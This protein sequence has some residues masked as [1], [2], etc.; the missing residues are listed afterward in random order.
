VADLTG[1]S[2]TAGSILLTVL[3]WTWSFDYVSPPCGRSGHAR[4][5]PVLFS[6]WHGFQLPL[7]YTHRREGINVLVSTHRDGEYVARVLGG[8]GFGTI[9]GSTTRGGAEALRKI[10]LSLRRGIDCA[11]TP[12]GPRGP[13]E[14][15]KPGAAFISRLSGRPV[16]AMGTSAWPCVRFRSWDRFMLPLPFSRMVIVEGRPVKV[17]RGHD[18]ESASARIASEMSRVTAF[19]GFLAS[20]SGR[21][22]A[23]AGSALGT[24]AGLAASV[25]LLRRPAGERRERQGFVRARRDGPVWLHGSSMGEISGL[26]PFA[27]HLVRAGVPVHVTCFTPAARS[28]LAGTGVQSSFLPLDSPAWVR[29][30]LDRI[31]PSAFII[32]ETELWP[33]TII[34]TLRRSVPCAMVNARLTERSVSRYRL[35]GR[36]TVG[37]LLSAFSGILCRS[38]GDAGRFLSLGADPGL[39]EV[40]GDGKSLS[41]A[42][43]PP[44]EWTALLHGS[45]RPVLVAGSTRDGEEVPVARAALAAGMLPVIV[46]RH[47]ERLGRIIESLGREGIVAVPWSR[48][49]AGTGLPEAVVVDGMGLLA[50]M[51]GCAEVAFVGGTLVPEGGHNVL[52]AL[53]RGV[54][55]VVGPDYRSFARV[56]DRGI[57]SGACRS[58]DADGLAGAFAEALAQRPSAASIRELG[59]E[60]GRRVMT[61]FIS[62]CSRMG[63]PAGEGS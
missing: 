46:P 57:A 60:D 37:R 10:A 32:A 27:E 25:A 24:L 21:V 53:R 6:F 22:F 19:A 13:A 1:L 2:R 8:M 12:D 18:L 42:G 47:L 33:N 15:L 17:V 40:A 58:A 26:L 29:R 49:G 61:A 36:G 56:V 11:I 43:D 38:E 54:P 59:E 30:F 4:G 44:P 3:G 52:E 28:K 9:R 50:R 14:E 34:E 39:V 45:G 48:L 31:S 62:L 23:A 41:D 7:I 16:V 35:L 51:Y 5:R 20:P 63:I 55:V